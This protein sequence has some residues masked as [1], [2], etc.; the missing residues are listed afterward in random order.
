MN[1]MMAELTRGIGLL[2]AMGS[3]RRAMLKILPLE[4][5]LF[6]KQ[7]GILCIVFPVFQY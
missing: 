7:A 3:A 5:P 6:V 2:M 1:L 4:N